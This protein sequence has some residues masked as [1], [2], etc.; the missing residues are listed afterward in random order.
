MSLFGSSPKSEFPTPVPMP[1]E[2]T[3]PHYY[4]PGERDKEEQMH[5]KSVRK[6]ALWAAKQAVK[7]GK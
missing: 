3:R 7:K 5:E 6:R 2:T 4:E 1:G